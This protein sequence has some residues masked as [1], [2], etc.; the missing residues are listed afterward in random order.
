MAEVDRTKG[1]VTLLRGPG[2][3]VRP[4]FFIEGVWNGPFQDGDFGE[5]DCVFG[6]GGILGEDSIRFVTSAATTDYLYYSEDGGQVTVSNSL[7][8]LLGYI[9]D[10]LDPRYLEY[11]EICDSIKDGI[12]KSLQP[13]IET[14][15]E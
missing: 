14:F 6:T 3:E 11:P 10:S 5:T 2:I 1:I 12:Q 7:P 4:N 13:P 8:L 9:D 15:A